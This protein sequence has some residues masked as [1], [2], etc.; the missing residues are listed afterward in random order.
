MRATAPKPSTE[1]SASGSCRCRDAASV[2][3]AVGFEA[4]LLVGGEAEQL[5]KRPVVVLTQRRAR[6]VVAVGRVADP[7][8]GALVQ[9]VAHVRVRQRDEVFPVPDL[10]VLVDVPE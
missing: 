2:E 10:R 7:G 9:P 6:P 3:G 1:V 4:L 5:A 8:T